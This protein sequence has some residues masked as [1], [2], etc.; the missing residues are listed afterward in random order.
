MQAKLARIGKIERK[1]AAMQAEQV[2][3]TA[4]FVDERIAFDEAHGFLADQA[5]YRG[6]L[7]EVAIARRVSVTTAASF[8]DEA[9]QLA[10]DHPATMAALQTGRIGLSAARS[11]VKETAVLNDP[12]AKAL[13][14]QVI[15]EEAPDVLPGKV[16][17][18]AERR[19]AEIDPDAVNRRSERER[20]DRH[21]GLAMAGSG[22]AWL[23]SYL[24][25]EQAK[26]AYDSVHEH[27]RSV[28]AAGDDGRTVSQIMADTLVERLTGSATDALPVDINVVMTDRTLL[29]LS[30]QPA[31]LVGG[32]PLP[33]P[34]ARLLAGSTNAWLRRF[35]TDPVVGS[36]SHGDSRRRR[37]DGSLRDLQV[38]RDQHCRGI[39]CGSRIVDIDH[40]HDHAKGGETT[41]SNGQ[42]LSKACHISRDDPRM[43]VERDEI[44]GVVTWTTPTGFTWRSLP[45]PSLAPGSLSAKQRRWR[46]WLL[47]PPESRLEQQTIH[48]TV[49]H[50]KHS[51]QHC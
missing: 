7:A 21:V 42:G 15:A 10:H 51:H 4:A 44:T 39:Q 37:F 34:T 6:M 40:I 28:Y 31:H 35:L 20:K 26:A 24:P 30:D 50:L 48:V 33:S 25:A 3:L 29:G 46:S 16:R 18:L 47:H 23:S 45:P 22:M 13:A 9:W 11:I 36:I 41:P 8:M 19:V 43:H 12:A 49:E 27:A 17:A 14:D 5:Q 38:V 2:A 32:G 1:I